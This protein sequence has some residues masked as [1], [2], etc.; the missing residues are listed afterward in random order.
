MK[1]TSKVK[2]CPEKRH[3][4]VR[5]NVKERSREH[6]KGTKSDEVVRMPL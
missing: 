6:E 3:E 2:H 5:R 1:V 4:K